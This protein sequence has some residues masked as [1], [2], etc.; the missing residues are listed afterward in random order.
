MQLWK[1]HKGII[2]PL[3]FLVSVY[4]LIFS[5]TLSYQSAWMHPERVFDFIDYIFENGRNF[6]WQDIHRS[7]NVEVFEQGHPRTTRPL[8]GP[9]LMLDSKIRSFLWRFVSP[10]P[11][12]SLL[13]IFTLFLSP[14]FLFKLLRELGATT[15]TSLLMVAFFLASPGTLSLVACLFRPSKPL[16]ICYILFTLYFLAKNQMENP[17]YKE[18][19]KWL[20]FY[21]PF[22]DET[23]F[24]IYPLTFFILPR[25]FETKKKWIFFFLLPFFNIFIYFTL[26]PALYY[27]THKNFPI[28]YTYHHVHDLKQLDES[29]YPFIAKFFQHLTLFWQDSFGLLR[30]TSLK[31]INYFIQL[32]TACLVILALITGPLIRKKRILAMLLLLLLLVGFHNTLLSIK[33]T[34][35]GIYWYGTYFSAFVAITLAFVMDVNKWTRVLATP[36]LAMIIFGLFQRFNETNTVYRSFHYYKGGSLNIASFFAGELPIEEVKD[37]APTH[38]K[39]AE[40]ANFIKLASQSGKLRNIDFENGYD[41]QVDEIKKKIY[42]P[43]SFLK[44]SNE[45]RYIWFEV[46]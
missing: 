31:P 46:K 13:M 17:K 19:L 27:V 14:F 33:E 20:C 37:P 29:G 34:P 11:S 18:K 44:Y 39:T 7:F 10:H 43:A 32:S 4:Y 25:F 35:W 22:L 23:G 21:A 24:L 5:Q 40:F 16:V 30:Q 42:Y 9:M 15:Y 12:L 8:E 41:I 1:N 38:M 6:Q 28:F 36:L 2:I 45:L 26:I 3:T